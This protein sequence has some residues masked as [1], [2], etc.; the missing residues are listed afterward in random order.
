M[1]E[2]VETG[3]LGRAVARLERLN[4]GCTYMSAQQIEEI[5]RAVSEGST[6]RHLSMQWNGNMETVEAGLLGRAVARLET[7]NVG[8]TVMSAQQIEEGLRTVTEGFTMRNLIMKGN[9][10]MEAVDAGL[11]GRAVARLERLDVMGTRLSVQQIREMKEA[12]R[13]SSCIVTLPPDSDDELG[14]Y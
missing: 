2:R 9:G 4:V 10:N 12:A 14:G 6:L 5:L 8:F 7:L 3:L 13:R 1:G 11:L